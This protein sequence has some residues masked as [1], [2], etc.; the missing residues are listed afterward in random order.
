MS[1]TIRQTAD[2][3]PIRAL[4]MAVFVEEQGFTVESEFDDLDAT[5]LHLLA[6]EAGEPIGCARLF[7]VEGEGRIGR[8]CVAREA[9]GKGIGAALVEAGV[10]HFRADGLNRAALSAQVQAQAFYSG[11]GFVPEGPIYDDEGVPH[12]M[13]ARAI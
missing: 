5:S 8:I 4:R 2:F 6:T 13:M 12:Q 9:R 10:A 7:T 1:V 3:A 11:L